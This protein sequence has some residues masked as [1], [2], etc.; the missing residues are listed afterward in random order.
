MPKYKQ[1]QFT[2]KLKNTFRKTQ[3]YRPFPKRAKSQALMPYMPHMPHMP[4]MPTPIPTMPAPIPRQPIYTTPPYMFNKMLEY[5]GIHYPNHIKSPNEWAVRSARRIP[6]DFL[7][8]RGDYVEDNSPHN[9]AT[10]FADDLDFYGETAI[11]HNAS[12]SMIIEKEIEL[13][14]MKP[15]PLSLPEFKL[16]LQDYFLKK[17]QLVSRPMNFHEISTF[18]VNM[19]AYFFWNPSKRPANYVVPT[20]RNIIVS[21]DNNYN[22]PREF[23]YTFNNRYGPPT[24]SRS[25][26]LT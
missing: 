22:G 13:N 6:S 24:Q 14:F 19:N 15:N 5:Q 3:H 25:H 1:G 17:K 9:Y 4:H 8:I 2:R 26:G 16:Y 11:K 18:N 10:Q 12:L 23:I 20:D 7:R 21:F